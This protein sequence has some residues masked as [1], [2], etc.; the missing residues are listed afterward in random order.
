MSATEF[1]DSI[2]ITTAF[3]IQKINLEIKIKQ[4][5]FSQNLNPNLQNARRTPKPHL[6][7]PFRE[8]R[9]PTLPPS[10]T[11]LDAR[12]SP[13]FDD[14]SASANFA[15]A[16]IIFIN[17]IFINNFSSIA[18]YL[19]FDFFALIKGALGELQLSEMDLG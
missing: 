4:N 14:F 19:L 2:Y 18:V 12:D 13:L 16:R 7:C 9:C 3:R 5:L 6:P 15:N 10:S 11:I 1:W 8:P 17:T